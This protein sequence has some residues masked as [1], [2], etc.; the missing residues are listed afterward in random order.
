MWIK[1]VN[2]L[3]V[4]GGGRIKYIDIAKFISVLFVLIDHVQYFS[5]V[6]NCFMVIR[7]IWLAFFMQMFFIVAGIISQYPIITSTRD[8]T[9]FIEKKFRTLL[10]PYII[11]CFFLNMSGNHDIFFYKIILGRPED[12]DSVGV[13][14]VLW[15]FP[16]LFMANIIVF[17][18]MTTI[19]CI[20]RKLDININIYY[21]I[22]IVAL[23]IIDRKAN[24]IFKDY[25]FFGLRSAFCAAALIFFG[26]LVKGMI[27]YI[28]INFS[29]YKKMIFF[30]LLLIA[31]ISLAYYNMP[32][33]NNNGNISY[34]YDVWVAMGRLGKS[35]LIFWCAS[36]C[37]SMGVLIFSMCLE[38]ISILAYLGER[39]LLFMTLHI[40]THSIV[41]IHIVPWLNRYIDDVGAMLVW[42][43][44][45]SV[46]LVVT[47]IPFIDKYMPF[48]YKSFGK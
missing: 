13:N 17:F 29:I 24:I 32:V 23:M 21:V 42:V 45:L 2:R 25:L 3:C 6:N 20:K 34:V 8:I 31:G 4:G 28:Y 48:L 30:I 40:Y 44:L 41:S 38:K 14:S 37:L 47:V 39:S 43:L 36:I 7:V 18:T 27:I 11:W 19:H 9:H 10:V 46:L 12:L 33:L 16:V 22:A 15:F 5:P 26:I 1:K 35:V